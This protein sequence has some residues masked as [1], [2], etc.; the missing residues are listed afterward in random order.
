MNKTIAIVSAVGSAII[1]V[2]GAVL[3]T[4]WVYEKFKEL[5]GEK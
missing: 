4:L 5:R 1:A 2:M 3:M